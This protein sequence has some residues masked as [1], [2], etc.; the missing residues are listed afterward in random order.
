MDILMLPPDPPDRTDILTAQLSGW[1]AADGHSC[2]THC[3]DTSPSHSGFQQSILCNQLIE[4]EKG[5]LRSGQLQ[6]C[7]RSWK[8][9]VRASPFNRQCIWSPFCVKKMWTKVKKYIHTYVFWAVW[10]PC[11]SLE[12]ES[13]M[14]RSV[15]KNVDRLMG[16]D[17]RD[18]D[19]HTAC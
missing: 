16:V 8:T 19:F 4:E 12:G 13:G 15:K 11:Q 10:A 9:K 18:E 14:R 5:K 6:P 1:S 2:I 17:T 7:R 3:T